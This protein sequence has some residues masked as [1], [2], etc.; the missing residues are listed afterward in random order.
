[1]EK[2][3]TDSN[4][5]SLFNQSC[6]VDYISNK[7]LPTFFPLTMSELPGSA[8]DEREI[9]R[10]LCLMPSYVMSLDIVSCPL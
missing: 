8:A 10:S 7:M 9:P 6:A 2:K 4:S 1:M 5:F 3:N